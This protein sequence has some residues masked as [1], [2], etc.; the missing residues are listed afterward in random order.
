MGQFSKK[1]F[2][3]VVTLS[4][5]LST[6]GT[7]AFALP[8]AASAATLVNGDLIK[9][10]RDSSV[11]YYF[12]NQRYV[13]PNA[14]TYFSWFRDFSTV[15]TISQSELEMIDLGTRNIT[16]RPGTKLVKIQ[17]IPKVYAVTA[18]GRL[19]W[20]Q[21]EQI[22]SSLYGANWARRVTDV[23]DSF[24]GNYSVD[25][26]TVS[27][28]VHPEGTLVSYAGSGDR[29]VVSNGMKRR[30][31][32]SAFAA[33]GFNSSDVVTTGIVYPN[34]T[35]V[36]G[37]EAGL[38]DLVAGGSVTP[39]PTPT[40]GNVTVSL[41]SDTTNYRSVVPKNA[42]NVELLR[43]NV[44][45]GSAAATINTLRLRRAGVGLTT[46]FNAVYVYKADGTR[47]TSGR[48]INSST[49]VV[50]FSGLNLEVPAGQSM[51]LVITGDIGGYTGFTTGGQ[52]YFE[53]ADASSVVMSGTGT[54]SGTFPITGRPV[55]IGTATV[56][57][58]DVDNG[59]TPA[60]PRVGSQDVEIANFKLVANGS[61]D[62]EIRRVTLYQGADI[63]NSDLTNLR[64]FQGSTQVASASGVLSSG[65]IVLNFTSPFL[66][67]NGQTRNFS[68][69]AAVSGRT[70][71]NIRIYSEYTTDVL[72]ID[73]VQG[74]GAQVCIGGS[75]SIASGD[76]CDGSYNGSG[77]TTTNAS[78]SSTEG[79]QFTI[80]YNGP[81]TAN[82]A[83]ASNDVVFYR[84]S[85]TSGS[86]DIEV[87]KLNF[88]V[89]TTGGG[90]LTSGSTDYLRDIKVKDAD[91]GETVVS[92][93]SLGSTAIAYKAFSESTSFTIR[94]GQT[95]NFL[96]TADTSS[97]VSNGI[98]YIFALGGASSNAIFGSTDL[99]VVNSGEFLTS[100]ISPNTTVTGNTMTVQAAALNVALAGS[101]SS[102]VYVK[103]QPMIP[104]VAFVLSAGSQNDVRVTSFK[105]TG[106]AT[107]SVGSGGSYDADLLDSVVN[108]CAMY[109]VSVE[110]AV[111][112]G[113]HVSP[114]S[115]GGT[116]TFSGLS[117]MIPRGS[118]KTIQ[119]RCT[120]DSS[121]SDTTN[122]DRFAL[123]ID[124]DSDVA[125][126]DNDGN[127]V[128]VTRTTAV[129]NNAGTTPSSFSVFQTVRANGTVSVS[130][131]S[132]RSSTILVTG[133]TM[134]PGENDGYQLMTTLKA[135]AQYED[136]EL[137]RLMV[138]STGPSANIHRVA[139][140]QSSNSDCTSY[141]IK[142]RKEFTAGQNA[143]TTLLFEDSRVVVPKGG[144][145][146]L[147][148][149]A[150]L[151]PT[152]NSSTNTDT[153][154]SPRSGNSIALGVA[155]GQGDSFFNASDFSSR[156][157]IRATGAASGERVYQSST[158]GLSGN[159]FV[160]RRSKPVVTNPNTTFQSTLSVGER[161]LWRSQ[162]GSEG[163]AIKL[164]QMIFSVSVVTT[165]NMTL[166]QFRLYKDGQMISLSDIRITDGATTTNLETATISYASGSSSTLRVVAQFSSEQTITSGA[167]YELR[168][169][170]GGLSSTTGDSISTSLT[171][172]SLSSA[173]TGYVSE[174]TNATPL[175]I[176][177][178]NSG[179]LAIVTG[180][181]PSSGNGGSTYGFI[182]SD[183]S[184]QGDHSA[185]AYPSDT[186]P[187]RDWTN[188]Y[189]VDTVS[190]VFVLN[191]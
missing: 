29:Y 167:T 125:A 43:L 118:S 27:S 25:T 19:Q 154:A 147:C 148:L 114:A 9:G 129:D 42:M 82:V 105:V 115:M 168:A 90:Y 163:G 37:R 39:T 79:G 182:W 14:T 130:T 136:M 132:L 26:A 36:T 170:I 69:R 96:I 3:T 162:I 86:N 117:Y 159:T 17:S 100:G 149:M 70:G 188:E 45:G 146:Y 178:V 123:G 185:T 50:E 92:A 128:T 158:A 183:D 75:G 35:D 180:T 62:V 41:N 61:N 184:E 67:P 133:A 52:H 66:I 173:V 28:S 121:I 142:A 10:P 46:D 65:Q 54:I 44:T 124:T 13:F 140:A 57:R 55:T 191:K 64:L 112:V 107:T 126:Q 38:A 171:T 177:G 59:S 87:R 77:S 113:N 187:S 83:R 181:V 151:A 15:K 152:V 81:A 34:G 53:V 175:T 23:P 135:S 12:G 68:L 31:S 91:T 47:L 8:T 1:F 85:I 166:G 101:P 179:D 24:W 99:R 127:T 108:T 95:R 88:V 4:T 18:G 176:G 122:G 16:I 22:A 174:P 144:S 98:G 160:V 139:L 164:K 33:N 155:A 5:V 189:L 7:A 73:R 143:T 103:N 58:V 80:T 74:V 76:G 138:S 97:D 110:P 48:T 71:R 6:M 11:Y 78:Y 157:N 51:T 21:S 56:A 102:G 131:D 94:A 150:K 32:D 2:S 109:D 63:S 161:T 190:T 119:V 169:T 165:S 40:T 89:T 49:N 156:L 120:A 153:T 186:T 104:A 172:Q 145:T 20:I 137:D 116:M 141:T 106:S 84:F 93:S 111:Q 72:A 60:N 134:A 30:I